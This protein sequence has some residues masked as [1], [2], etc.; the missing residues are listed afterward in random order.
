MMDL[1]CPEFIS[2]D[3]DL[4]GE[5]TAMIV[6]NWMIEKDLDNPGFIP[7]NF[8]FIVH[9]ANPIGKQNIQGKLSSYLKQR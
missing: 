8:D 9:S 7:A 4:G 1:C 6:V 2:F 5:D 3:H